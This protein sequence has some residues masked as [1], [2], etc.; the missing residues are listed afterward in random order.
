M[1]IGDVIRVIDTGAKVS[2]LAKGLDV[3]G[4]LGNMANV[5]GNV[6]NAS[7]ITAKEGNDILAKISP[8]GVNDAK[9]FV[10]L[11]KDNG[12][13]VQVVDGAD[14]KSVFGKELA[15]ITVGDFRAQIANG[16]IEA[17]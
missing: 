8:D 5:L 1:A 16:D 11:A 15:K 2:K 13:E 9:A 6:A 12:F 7:T 17:L 14:V 4:K 10:P 3:A